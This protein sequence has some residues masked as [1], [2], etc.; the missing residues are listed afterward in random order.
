MSD[1]PVYLRANGDTKHYIKYQS[2][3]DCVELSSFSDGSNDDPV[4]TFVNGVLQ[5]T[6]IYYQ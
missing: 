4:F 3:G 1:N 5:A 6:Q 2:T